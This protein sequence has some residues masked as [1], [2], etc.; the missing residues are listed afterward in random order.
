MTGKSGSEITEV[1]ALGRDAILANLSG[2]ALPDLSPL[3]FSKLAVL[4][5]DEVPSTPL[6]RYRCDRCI[7][8]NSQK[9]SCTIVE[10]KIEPNKWCV[11]WL[12]RYPP[13]TKEATS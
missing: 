1:F 3:K 12:P 10:G 6:W 4:Y 5:M 13:A 8:F 7:L 9:S 11:L 2:Q